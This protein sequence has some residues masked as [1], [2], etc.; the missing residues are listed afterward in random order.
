MTSYYTDLPFMARSSCSYCMEL[1]FLVDS[2]DS[3]AVCRCSSAH[4]TSCVLHMICS[5][6]KVY[7]NSGRNSNEVSTT[8]L[9]ELIC[10][11]L[12]ASLISSCFQE[13]HLLAHANYVS[14]GQTVKSRPVV[15][16]RI[17]RFYES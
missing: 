3:S 16:Y 12:Q 11:R 4:F 1:S 7:T 9:F 5:V 13:V 17:T 6:S 10:L 8:V 15:S 14:T 2:I